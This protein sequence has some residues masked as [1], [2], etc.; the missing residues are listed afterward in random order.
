MNI[1]ARINCTP[2]SSIHAGRDAEP[3]E[4]E[5][6]DRERDGNPGPPHLRICGDLPPCFIQIKVTSWVRLPEQ[7][8]Q[9]RHSSQ[10]GGKPECALK[11]NSAERGHAV[12]C[13]DLLL[14]D[15]LGGSE[16]LCAEDHSDADGG[17]PVEWFLRMVVAT[18]EQ[19]RGLLLR[20]ENR[21]EADDADPE[22]DQEERGPLVH[23]QLPVKEEP[24]ESAGEDDDGTAKHLVDRG[25]GVDETNLEIQSVQ[26][27]TDY[28]PRRDRRQPEQE[29]FPPLELQA[30]MLGLYS[31]HDSGHDSAVTLRDAVPEDG[32]VDDDHAECF[33]N[34]HVK[35][36][37]DRLFEVLALRGVWV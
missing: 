19:V 6:R 35:G 7:Q 8:V 23:A 26:R 9:H 25:R 15:E 31:G 12:L 5:E 17:F 29:H 30:A 32:G 11:T 10:D 18:A 22:D 16:N 1:P 28:A 14:D 24:A 33:T 20:E 36:L 4:V 3:K 37:E 27:T 21:G 13:H 34:E 2:C